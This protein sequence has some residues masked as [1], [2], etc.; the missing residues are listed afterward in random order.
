MLYIIIYIYMKFFCSLFVVNKEK[1]LKKNFI[2]TT[3][4][5]HADV[6]CRSCTSLSGLHCGK[7]SNH[8]YSML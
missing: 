4:W 2:Q 7:D 8:G 3:V 1:D 6:S 5:P